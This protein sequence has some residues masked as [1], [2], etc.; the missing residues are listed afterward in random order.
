MS[1]QLDIPDVCHWLGLIQKF[2][3]AVD[4]LLAPLGLSLRLH[5]G[6]GARSIH[7]LAEIAF[8]VYKFEHLTVWLKIY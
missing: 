7:A 3:D 4:L 5:L 2:G 6:P 8:T 1:L